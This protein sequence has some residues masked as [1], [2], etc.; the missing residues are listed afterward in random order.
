MIFS[1]LYQ[2]TAHTEYAAN[3]LMKGKGKLNYEQKSKQRSKGNLR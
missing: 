1:T 3:N 2:C